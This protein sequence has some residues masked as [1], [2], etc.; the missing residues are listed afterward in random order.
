M[1]LPPRPEQRARLAA[2]PGYERD[3]D[4]G[5]AAVERDPGAAVAQG[6]T[7]SAC[8]AASWT[9]RSGTPASCLLQLPALVH[10]PAAPPLP[11]P[12][13]GRRLAHAVGR[14]QGRGRRG[15]VAA[16]RA[17]PAFDGAGAERLRTALPGR[18]GGRR[19]P[20]TERSAAAVLGA[21]STARLPLQGDR[22][23][24]LHRRTPPPV[25]RPGKT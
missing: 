4:V 13:W 5:G 9:S 17:P 21:G 19:L 24:R 10:E 6:G 22:H 25:P 16:R 3:D 11:R 8:E 1:G 12:A 15:A 18:L 7:G 23:G 20:A 14:R 2:G